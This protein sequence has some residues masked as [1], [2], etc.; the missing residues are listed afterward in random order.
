MVVKVQGLWEELEKVK[1]R[2]VMERAQANNIHANCS[3][4]AISPK[5]QIHLAKKKIKTLG[6]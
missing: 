6:D 1:A 3:K 4:E 5:T 2:G